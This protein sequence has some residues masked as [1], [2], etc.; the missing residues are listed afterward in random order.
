M[1]ER[2]AGRSGRPAE[3]RPARP[4][5]QWIVTKPRSRSIVLGPMPHTPPRLSTLAKGPWRSRYSTIRRAMEGPIPGSFSKSASEAEFRSIGAGG[6]GAVPGALFPPSRPPATARQ[7]FT[8]EKTTYSLTAAIRPSPTPG[9]LDSSSSDPNG[10][11]VLPIGHDPSGQAGA[12]SRQPGDLAGAGAVEIDPL[13][14]AEGLIGVGGTVPMGGQRARGRPQR[15]SGHHRAG[16]GLRARPARGGPPGRRPPGRAG[17]AGRV[18]RRAAPRHPSPRGAEAPYRGDASLRLLAQ[19]P[20]RHIA[21]GL[22]ALAG[23][24]VDGVVPG[25]P[26]GI[27]GI[28]MDHVDGPDTDL[29]Q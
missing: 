26:V 3:Q 20:H 8:P 27:V 28:E 24:L 6:S 29:L 10:P 7:S 21:H 16:P 17:A 23:D 9:T 15:Q 2:A 14:G 5:D 18:V 13:A 4:A 11:L 12:Y 1:G 25:V 22:E 19:Q